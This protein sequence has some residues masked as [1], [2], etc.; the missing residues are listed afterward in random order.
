MNP[1][2]LL[3]ERIATERQ[4]TMN[5]PTSSSA[6]FDLVAQNAKRR[7]IEAQGI[8]GTKELVGK[9]VKQT[10]EWKRITKLELENPKEFIYCT[11]SVSISDQKALL[12]RL[13]GLEKKQ[14]AN[15]EQQKADQKALC[16][17]IDQ[18]QLSNFLEQ[19]VEEQTNRMRS[20]TK[21]LE[22]VGNMDK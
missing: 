12:R 21:A 4:Q 7:R 18:E 22:K 11:V 8:E 5:L 19:L 15:S 3:R 2:N 20:S 6:G 1:T 16:A 13:N 10:E 9:M 14:A 17:T